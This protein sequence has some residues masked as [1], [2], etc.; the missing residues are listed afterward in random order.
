LQKL[1][2]LSHQAGWAFKASKLLSAA[3]AEA[4][5]HGARQLPEL[6]CA[7]SPGLRGLGV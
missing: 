1:S 3:Q 7:G 6:G 4:L 2:D 5:T